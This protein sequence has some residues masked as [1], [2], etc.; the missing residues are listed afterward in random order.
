MNAEWSALDKRAMQQALWAPY[1][2]HQQTDFFASDVD[3]RCYVNQVLFLFEC[4][5]ICKK[6]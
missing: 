2:N 5:H 3:L 4:D 6:N 1:L